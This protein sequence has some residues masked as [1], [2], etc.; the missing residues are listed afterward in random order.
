MPIVPISNLSTTGPIINSDQTTKEWKVGNYFQN[1]ELKYYYFNSGNI[2]SYKLY[3]C[4][5]VGSRNIFTNWRYGYE[6]EIGIQLQEFYLDD[7]VTTIN[8]SV[9]FEVKVGTQKLITLSE[10]I[11]NQVKYLTFYYQPTYTGLR[12]ENG[13]NL[14]I[15]KLGGGI[16]SII[17]SKV[18]Q[19]KYAYNSTYNNKLYQYDDTN[20][21]KI[22]YNLS[23]INSG[24][25]LKPFLG[26]ENGGLTSLKFG[27]GAFG[28]GIWKTGVWNDG[29]WG[30]W[31][32][33]DT[34]VYYFQY[35][36]LNSF[37]FNPNRWY[38]K[39]DSTTENSNVLNIESNL[40]INDF[41]SVGNIVGIDINEDR[42]LLKDYYRV[43]DIEKVDDYITITLDIP[44]AKFP[45][46]RFEVDS[47]HHLVYV[48]K[49]IWLGGTFL[50]G[51]FNGIWN[52]GLFKGF[53][54]TTVMEDSHFISGQFDGGRFKSTIDSF[55]ANS[56][57]T[58]NYQTG[59]I[60]YFEFFDNNVSETENVRGYEDNIYKSWID[61]NYF[62]QSY[63]NLN[64][65]TNIYDE[66][67]GKRIS[68]PNLYG[69]PT[70]DVISS[71]SKF[72]NS[73][74][75]DIE[76]YNLGIKYKIYTDLLEQNGYFTKP[77]SSVDKP[78]LDEFDNAGWILEKGN[79]FGTPT[80]SFIYTSNVNRKNFNRMTMILATFGYNILNNSSIVV[81]DKKYTI[82]EYD[83][84][85]FSR[86][87]DPSSQQYTNSF[88][89]PLYLLGSNF[90][91]PNNLF[92]SGIT[93]T[94][95]FYNKSALD[96]VLRY[97]SE[98]DFVPNFKNFIGFNYVYDNNTG[99][100]SGSY[101]TTYSIFIPSTA[102]QYLS[103]IDVWDENGTY[104]LYEIVR[105]D[106]GLFNFF[107][108]LTDS[109][110]FIPFGKPS[111]TS[112]Y[113]GK[114]SVAYNDTLSESN[115]LD[116]SEILGFFSTARFNYFRFLE[117]DALPFFNYFDFE[118]NFVSTFNSGG[119][120]GL[121]FFKPHGFRDGD[122]VYLTMDET[123]YNPQY[124]GTHSVVFISDGLK[125]NGD[126]I[127]T[128]K[129]SVAYGATV[130][131]YS[132]TG[133]LKKLS[134]DR[135]D[136]RIQTNFYA[137][138]PKIVGLD[139]NFVYLGNNQILVDRTSFN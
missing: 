70:R 16:L 63:V 11:T 17:S 75:K 19:V 32:L 66:N 138:A 41:V 9:R 95:Y 124:I 74:D 60:Q 29:W 2:G 45:I 88:N 49:S 64:S 128:V 30:N 114:L 125:T 55:T 18:T 80:A 79:F 33:D 25:S 135:I 127:Y 137:S 89:K 31:K 46:R 129:L 126:T 37:E 24:L 28:S 50:N 110:T 120:L 108:S 58:I 48:S 69:Y 122:L 5:N 119:D 98:F 81:N 51:Y 101:A 85:Y 36:N 92:R 40:K 87:F 20:S 82:V 53:P 57:D 13:K 116:E 97:N 103:D 78:G 65:L 8:N 112:S 117:V 44:V 14:W 7:S 90:S 61:V 113:W 3:I 105:S 96:M 4:D 39:I 72:K 136:Q 1:T 12:S 118:V 26:N 76:F 27:N 52:Y 86:G 38:L 84:D 71:Y 35:V 102:S 56:G 91:S 62:T 73:T 59:L 34:Q 23:G 121:E 111:A 99:E 93:K 134:G 106:D 68:L 42:Y 104:N 132:E 94:E 43:T 22:P 83:L 100:V 47:I 15:R 54:Y 123:K 21:V 77:F 139:E 6:I 107:M 130:S 109:N 133:T 10:K 67:F 131:N 115:I